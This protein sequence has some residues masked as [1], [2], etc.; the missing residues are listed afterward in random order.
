MVHFCRHLLKLTNVEMP[1]NAFKCYFVDV[2]DNLTTSRG[3]C[4]EGEFTL[5]FLWVD[6]LLRQILLMACKAVGW[7]W[8][9]KKFHVIK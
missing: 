3:V 8:E 5:H 9:L 7:R 6:G 2:G 1:V 4:R